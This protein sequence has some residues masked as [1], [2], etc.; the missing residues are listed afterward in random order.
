MIQIL[1]NRG[2]DE[3]MPCLLFWI[4]L[5]RWPPCAKLRRRPPGAWLLAHSLH[6]AGQ[7]TACNRVG[8]R[9]TLADSPARAAGAS[10]RE[11]R[12]ASESAKRRG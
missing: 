9:R 12:A 8:V 7:G 11:T 6:R 4:N 5:C 10:I 2:L 3:L 1:D